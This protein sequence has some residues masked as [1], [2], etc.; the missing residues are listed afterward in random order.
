MCELKNYEIRGWCVSHVLR[1]VTILKIFVL[2]GQLWRPR[3][4]REFLRMPE[5]GQLMWM[6]KREVLALWR[7][8]YAMGIVSEAFVAIAF[9]K[10]LDLAQIK[11][12]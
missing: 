5:L 6:A 9:N 11:K 8:L 10:M 12:R 1:R 4:R 2:N 7:T 3:V